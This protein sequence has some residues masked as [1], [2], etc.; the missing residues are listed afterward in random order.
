MYIYIYIYIHTHT[1]THTYTYMYICTYT[2]INS[3]I[4]D[5]SRANFLFLACSSESTFDPP[6]PAKI[7]L[8][9]MIDI[10][11]LYARLSELLSCSA[12]VYTWHV[13]MVPIFSMSS[14]LLRRRTRERR[15]YSL[16]HACGSRPCSSKY[17]YVRMYVR[18]RVYAYV[19]IIFDAWALPDCVYGMCVCLYMCFYS[20][21][22]AQEHARGEN[23]VR[24]L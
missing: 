5:T 6:P 22:C 4:I 10:K 20:S 1:H 15:E 2:Y 18:V 11:P 24:R 23:I 14:L 3:I 13:G 12:L 9:L 7:K 16:T 17:V 8:R 19:C 21:Y